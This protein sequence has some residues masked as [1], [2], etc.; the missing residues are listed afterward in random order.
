MINT[1][2]KLFLFTIILP[3][4]T[5]AVNWSKDFEVTSP[6]EN[7]YELPE[8]EFKE[9]VLN[10]RR[11]A[12]IY[13]VSVTELKIPYRPLRDF[14]ESDPQDPMRK[15]VFDL[16]KEVSPFKSIGEVF[17][18]L[19]LNSF[20][21]TPQKESP[22]SLPELKDFEKK[23][24]LGVTLLENEEGL[25][26]TFGCATCHSGDL[27]GVKVLGLTNR[28]PRAN[29]FFDHGA[30]IAPYV[31]S[32]LFKNML[33]TTEGERIMMVKA[34]KSL[35]YVGTKIPVA[36]GLD[37]SLA[38][39][40]LSLSKRKPD[41]YASKTKTSFRFPRKNKL[42]TMISDSKPAVWW[43]VKYKNR[44]LSDGSIVSG[45]PV[46]TNFLWNEIGRGTDLVKLEKWLSSN[47]KIV[48]ELTTA[49]FATKPP[50][51]ENFFGIE[52][53]D[54]EKAKRGEKH[55]IVSCQRCHGIY[56][57][58]WS[59]LERDKLTKRELLQTLKVKYHARTPVKDVG[60]DPG[61]YLGMKEFSEDLNRLRISQSLGTVVE[62]QKGYVP[63]PL[64][65]IW[66]RWPYFHNNSIPNLC[67]LLM[68][69]PQRPKTYWAGSA[70]DKNKDFDQEC[71][72]YPVGS[73]T[74]SEW[75]KDKDYY[76]DSTREGL[77]NLGHDERIFIKE[78]QELFTKEEK[79]ELIE[80]LKT[81]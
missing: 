61:R 39:V 57:K 22:N 60:T 53:I 31:N 28:F 47:T 40:A 1:M 54:L 65:G 37:T 3:S 30:K 2:Y 67:A 16:T 50:R 73:K 15:I 70:R 48:E 13:P 69:G 34:K 25:G 38:Q 80:F 58:G 51:Y 78:G 23:Y 52:A 59:G 76:Y 14:F 79:M 35:N 64:D 29:H 11:H 46:H 74:P 7:I 17:V 19:G 4:W 77:S 36:L 56:E 62:P 45:N 32:F 72:G 33:Q 18:W 44:W 6:R 20:P 12:L 68:P 63:P 66:A 21:E 24:P 41:E 81:L 55:Y 9:T 43:N 10:G 27:F 5:Y 42:E 26:M 8:K 49:V 71:V 75:K